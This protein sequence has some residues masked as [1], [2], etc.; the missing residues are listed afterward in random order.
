[1]P[2]PRRAES[3]SVTS[4]ISPEVVQWW[5]GSPLTRSADR[6]GASVRSLRA[7]SPHHRRPSSHHDRRRH[8]GAPADYHLLARVQGRN[9][10]AISSAARQ[11]G[12]MLRPGRDHGPDPIVGRRPH[13]A[14]TRLVETA[15]KAQAVSG[16]ALG[17]TSIA[18]TRTVG[19]PKNRFSSAAG[20]VATS[21]LHQ[22]R[23][24]TGRREGRTGSPRSNLPHCR[25]LHDQSP[26]EAA[27]R[28][29]GSKTSGL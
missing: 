19:E 23:G 25:R 17:S 12:P 4:Q 27:H 16:M 28:P 15:A 14:R 7:A 26:G 13:Q 22:G 9:V 20:S 10:P 5:T 29:D 1:M 11:H 6:N 21:P 3:H 8:P 2:L 18:S 24:N